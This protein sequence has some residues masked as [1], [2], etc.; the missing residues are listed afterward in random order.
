M[1][2]DIETKHLKTR[3]TY[4]F[5]NTMHHFFINKNVLDIGCLDGYS[6]YH[7]IK[8]NAKN[9]IGIDIE[10]KYIEKAKLKYPDIVF[11]VQDAE[12]IEDD[13]FNNI[14]VVSCL[15]L[16]YLLNNP[17]KFINNLSAQNKS[18]TI[19]IE[20]VDNNFVSYS[21]NNFYFLN[22][23]I[24]KKIFTDNNWK[25]SLEKRFT[26][27]EIDHQINENINFANRVILVFER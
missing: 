19:I 24:V 26:V 2:K 3:W 22:I 25:V 9:A 14:D 27:K 17:I 1:N 8:H 7:F 12:S 23:N 10:S 21:K 20:T 11:K 13:Y 6:T 18:N 4:L 16:I 15:G 5:N